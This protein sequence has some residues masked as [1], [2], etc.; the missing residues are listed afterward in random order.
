M[1]P[2]QDDECLLVAGAQ[3]GEQVRIIVHRA[4]LGWHR[5]AAGTA[6]APG[7]GCRFDFENPEYR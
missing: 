5:R 6:T 4:S 3:P 2:D 1:A 7:P